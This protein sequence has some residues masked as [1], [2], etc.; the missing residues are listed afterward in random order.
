[1]SANTFNDDAVSRIKRVVKNVEKSPLQG[2]TYRRRGRR[3]SQGTVGVDHPWK[4]SITTVD[5][6][7]Y[8]SINAGVIYTDSYVY[9][10]DED[11]EEFYWDYA[12]GIPNYVPTGLVNLSEYVD[13]DRVRIYAKVANNWEDGGRLNPSPILTIKTGGGD[14]NFA[15]NNIEFPRPDLGHYFLSVGEIIVEAIPDTNPVE[16]DYNILQ[17]RKTNAGINPLQ[18]KGFT[19]FGFESAK[20]VDTEDAS[21]QVI[22]CTEGYAQTPDGSEIIPESKTTFLR[23]ESQ[24]LVFLNITCE[25]DATNGAYKNYDTDVVYL[26]TTPDSTDTDIYYYIGANFPNSPTTFQVLE[27]NFLSPARVW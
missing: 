1:M 3:V 2:A 7:K 27:G 25:K 9:E 13:G 8:C 15:G 4:M 11:E 17:I 6:V 21:T 19:L 26:L 23:S 5:D 14:T 22:F 16:F 18:F 20:T 24:R 12:G 10:Y